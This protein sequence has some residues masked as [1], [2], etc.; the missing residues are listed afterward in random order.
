MIVQKFGGTS[1][2]GPEPIRRLAS[3]VRAALERRP[4]VV[5]SA[6]GGVTN[7]LFRL[8]E[9]ARSGE[10]WQAEYE[11][12]ARAHHETLAGLGLD[13][14]LLDGMLAEFRSLVHGVALLRECTARTMDS[15]ASYGERLSARLVAAYLA[16]TGL[17]ARAV[18]AWE[19]GIVTDGRFGSARPLPET[20]ER[21]R[22][23]LGDVPGVPVVTGY[24]GKDAQGNVTTLGRGG[25]DFSAAILGAAL[26][27][28]EIQIWTDVDGVMT[29]DP[30]IVERARFVSKLS[31]AE[32]AELAFFGAKV[33][34]PATMAPA[35][36]KNVPIRVLNSFRP[37]HPGTVIV[38]CLASGERGVKSITSKEEIAVVNVIAAPMLLQFGF[39]ERIAEVF[40]RH[41]I[42][43]DMI[44]TS[45][46]SVA[47]TT[48]A[49]ARLEPAVLELSRFSDVTIGRA[50]SLVS[51]VGAELQDGLSVQRR[52]FETLEELAVRVEM[53]SYGATR[54]NLSFVVA[55]D[56]VREIVRAL[57]RRLFE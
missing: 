56:R 17:P 45:E 54:N 39:L 8:A 55:R 37:E 40:A 3:I 2:G 41:E 27:A 51:I 38:A 44:A 12:L 25:S 22:A 20:E 18:D 49:T 31:F 9:L 26:G 21:I 36:Q 4:V 50:L 24:I 47:L 57:H 52:A 19:A 43:V 42:V 35:V 30:R 1:V 29:A 33:L 6:I 11:A 10:V 48:D 14:A 13:V 34:H 16:S 7:R 32:A 46:V 5:V 23:A 53:I 15:L 28:D